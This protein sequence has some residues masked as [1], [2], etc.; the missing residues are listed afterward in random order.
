MTLRKVLVPCVAL[1][2]A[3]STLSA[4]QAKP[5][6]VTGAWVGSFERTPGD[7]TDIRFNLT[8]KGADLTGTAGPDADRQRP[9]ANGKVTAVKDVTSVT[10]D[11][12]QPS[13]LVM[14][15]DLKVTEGRLKG[16]VTAE[17]NGEKREGQID[18]A[19]SK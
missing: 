5:V 18:V 19:R 10:F 17:A 2:I 11:L 7:K 6:D 4:R 14:S 15:F 3:A 1:L 8:Q 9:I 13:G 16:K 12:T